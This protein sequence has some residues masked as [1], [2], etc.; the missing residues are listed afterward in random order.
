VGAFLSAEKCCPLIFPSIKS[1]YHGLA[2]KP[3]S[4]WNEPFG[5]YTLSLTRA[6]ASELHKGL[7]KG[8]A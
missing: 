2:A 3:A 7:H 1:G 6:T 8:V 4:Q 5:S